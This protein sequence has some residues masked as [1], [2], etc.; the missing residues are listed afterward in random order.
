M[1]LSGCKEDDCGDVD[2]GPHDDIQPSDSI[3]EVISRTPRTNKASSMFS[4]PSQVSSTSSA[5]LKL[6]AEREELLIRAAFLKKRQDI[7]LEEACLKARKEQ[8][9]LEAKIS[10]SDAKIK[11]LRVVKMA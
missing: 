11:I 7:E 2:Y 5:R 4:Y 6:E 9:E 10:A 3:S 8:L 1:V